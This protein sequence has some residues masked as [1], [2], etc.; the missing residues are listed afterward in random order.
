MG[1]ISVT[2]N[3]PGAGYTST[4]TFPWGSAYPSKATPWLPHQTGGM[5]CTNA[6]TK[7]ILHQMTWWDIL[8]SISTR[9]RSSLGLAP[10]T[11]HLQQSQPS[12]VASRAWY[13][14]SQLVCPQQLWPNHNENEHSPKRENLSNKWLWWPWGVPLSLRNLPHKVTLSRLG[15]GADLP[16][17]WQTHRVRQSERKRNTF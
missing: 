15:Y 5:S 11:A 6:H 1:T 17:T 12:D 8:A 16:N 10:S 2:F 14:L 4:P 13:Q 7:W 3:Q 9:S